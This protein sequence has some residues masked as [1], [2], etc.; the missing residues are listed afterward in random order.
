M[1][2]QKP[3]RAL[4][5]TVAIRLIGL[6]AVIVALEPLSA[7]GSGPSCHETVALTTL[8]S[9]SG[10]DGGGP[11]ARLLQGTDGNFYGTTT[12]GGSAGLGTIFAITPSGILTLLHSFGGNDG[13]LP[14]GGL[15]QGIDGDFYGTTS[16]GGSLGGGTIFKVT[17]AGALTTIWSFGAGGISSPFG[18]L[19]QK[20]DGIFYGVTIGNTSYDR[21]AVFGFSAATGAFIVY[22]F[23]GDDDTDVQFPGATLV[24]GRDGSLYGTTLGGSG[25]QLDGAD[26]N[27]TGTAFRITPSGEH[28]VIHA[29]PGEAFPT[30]S[31]DGKIPMG[32]LA[33][34]SD[35]NLY[36]RAA[37]GGAHGYG[38]IFKIDPAS[39]IPQYPET[40]LYSFTG[41]TESWQIVD[42]LIQASNGNFYGTRAA[43]EGSALG[44]IF[45]VSPNGTLSVL[46][47]FTGPDGGEP[48][49]GLIQATDGNFFGSTKTG[50]A[51]GKGT[52]FE[53]SQ[54]EVCVAPD[55]SA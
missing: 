31:T 30:G 47:T 54:S 55:E 17:P 36:G 25:Q 32:P 48:V 13:K 46:H 8:H 11:Y 1:N 6:F 33:F 19:V 40:E 41:G 51:S 49:A 4:R 28:I 16:S 18:N 10:S 44:T 42:G 23:T 9:F 15:I 50:G 29:F 38:T 12:G 21:G 22:A 37:A 5:N 34:G 24:L 43:T 52:I 35:G 20:S 7:F 14:L 39:M 27:F 2:I 3:R 45:E 26:L 53:L